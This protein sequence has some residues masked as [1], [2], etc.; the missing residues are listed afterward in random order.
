[1]V[2]PIVEIRFPLLGSC[3]TGNSPVLLVGLVFGEEAA[4]YSRSEY[5][6]CELGHSKNIFFLALKQRH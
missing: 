6:D 5:I 1:M 2:K 3:P 4:A